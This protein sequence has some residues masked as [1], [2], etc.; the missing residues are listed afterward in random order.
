[1]RLKSRLNLCNASWIFN[2]MVELFL[3]K[4]G[5][6]ILYDLMTP[7]SNYGSVNWIWGTILDK[8]NQW[9]EV[10]HD[11]IVNSHTNAGL[12]LRDYI[13]VKYFLRSLGLVVMKGVGSFHANIGLMQRNR[14]NRP[15]KRGVSATWNCCVLMYA[16]FIIH[17]RSGMCSIG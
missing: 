4:E 11:S 7:I 13:G 6:T 15:F 14:I 9:I 8:L 17:N 10:G 3:H 12:I 1:M 2:P 16:I 5:L